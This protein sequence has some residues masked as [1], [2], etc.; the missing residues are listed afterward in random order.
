MT[1]RDS[2]NIFV[3]KQ[4]FLPNT[5]LSLSV[6]PAGGMDVQDVASVELMSHFKELLVRSSLSTCKENH[7]MHA[8]LSDKVFILCQDLFIT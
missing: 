8:G 1:L 6:V 2:H 4:F 3:L 5:M 7:K